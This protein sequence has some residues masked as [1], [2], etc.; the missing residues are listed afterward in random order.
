MVAGASAAVAV[1]CGRVAP[2]LVAEVAHSEEEEPKRMPYVRAPV[3]M[4]EPAVAAMAPTRNNNSKIIVIS[5][6]VRTT[7]TIPT[8]IN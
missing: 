5:S 7:F 3:S 6:P 1:S 2:L 8:I 4:M